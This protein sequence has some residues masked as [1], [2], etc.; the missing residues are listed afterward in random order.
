M[1]IETFLSAGLRVPGV[2]V[3]V[4]PPDGVPLLHVS[5]IPSSTETVADRQGIAAIFPDEIHAEQSNAE[6]Q[7]EE[8]EIVGLVVTFIVV[9]CRFD[10][11]IRELSGEKRSGR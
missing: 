9:V 11:V 4:P 7:S 5:L 8:D 3:P 6:K 10:V 1:L 2:G